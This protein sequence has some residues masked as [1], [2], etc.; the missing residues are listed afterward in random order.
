MILR[1]LAHAIREQHWF[2]LTLELVVVVIGIFIGLEVNDWNQKRLERDSDQRA[3]ALF[4]DELQ[5]MLQEARVDLRYVTASMQDLSLGT[6]IAL[7]CDASEDERARLAAA[8]GSTLNWRVPDVR[9]SGLAE[10][11]NSGT[12]ARLGNPDLSRAVGSIHQ[13]IKTIDDS[14]NFIAPQ[15]DRAWQM[16]LPYL[17]LTGPIR[18]K[19]IDPDVTRPPSEYLSLVPQENL[20]GSQEFLLGLSLLTAFYESSVYNFGEW[21]RVL[22]TA[23]ELAE[24]ETR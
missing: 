22:T 3:L 18:P 11:G 14:M 24:A 7:K 16:I 1:R 9:P 21:N 15:Y 17:V 13:S 5:L 8:I 4:I 23:H 10:I 2:A 12:L 19:T 20:C 6:E